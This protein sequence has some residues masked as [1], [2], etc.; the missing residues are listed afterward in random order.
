M[1]FSSQTTLKNTRGSTMLSLAA[2]SAWRLRKASQRHL[3]GTEKD[4][5]NGSSILHY[6]RGR[7][8]S[9]FIPPVKRNKTRSKDILCSD[10]S[11]ESGG[12]P[13]QGVRQAVQQLSPYCSM[14]LIVL[15]VDSSFRCL[16]VYLRALRRPST[17]LGGWSLRTLIQPF[18]SILEDLANAPTG[19]T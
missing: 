2:I 16:V 12:P 9:S 15:L 17:L 5:H 6:K 8:Y 7:S 10:I 3:F 13:Q 19:W 18:I 14:L 11:Q 1:K 4:V